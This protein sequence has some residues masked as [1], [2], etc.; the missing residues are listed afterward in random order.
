VRSHPV[1][2]GLT[3]A[4]D[5]VSDPLAGRWCAS[6]PLA[7]VEEHTDG[8]TLW[9]EDVAGTPERIPR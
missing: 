8:V 5:R 1:H 3:A 4:V 7:E 6:M 9:L 2:G